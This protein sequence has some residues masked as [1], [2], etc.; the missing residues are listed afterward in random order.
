TF[1]SS[2]TDIVDG[3]IT[4]IVKPVNTIIEKQPVQII[5]KNSGTI[6]IENFSAGFYT[7]GDTISETGYGVILQS[8]QPNESIFYTF[9]DSVHCS[10]AI[11]YLYVYLDGVT[12]DL[13]PKNDTN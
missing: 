4:S 11:R 13:N 1:F 8:I 12:D 5:I 7:T 2:I 6:A 9:D 10:T 3:S